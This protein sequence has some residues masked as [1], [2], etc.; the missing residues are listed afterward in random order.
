MM[1]NEEVTLDSPVAICDDVVWREL[2]GEAVILNLDSG[3]YFGLD[4][5]GTRMW[6]LVQESGSLRRAFEVLLEEYE[7]EAQRLEEDLLRLVERLRG[8]GLLR[9][10]PLPE[11]LATR[12]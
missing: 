8:N 6:A 5:V 4:P 11:G 12:G 1:V 3:I 7:V 9:V 10:T 2:E